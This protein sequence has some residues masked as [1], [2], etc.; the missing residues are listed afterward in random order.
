MGLDGIIHEIWKNMLM[1]NDG[2]E[3][4]DEIPL[5]LPKDNAESFDIA[6]YLKNLYNDI[7][8]HGVTQGTNFSEE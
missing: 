4:E 5:G 3:E 8:L 7:V 2:R 6:E 1:S